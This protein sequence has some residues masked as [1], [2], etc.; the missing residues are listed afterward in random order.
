MLAAPTAEQIE[1]EI[2]G[3]EGAET[4]E[5]VGETEPAADGDES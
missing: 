2:G 4:P 5:P 1:A 3:T